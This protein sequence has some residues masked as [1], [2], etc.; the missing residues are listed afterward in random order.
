MRNFF[1]KRR[2]PQFGEAGS[3]ENVRPDLD[4]RVT[5][6]GPRLV[7]DLDDS[8][9][10]DPDPDHDRDSDLGGYQGG[11]HAG[12]EDD[13]PRAHRQA[14]VVQED[15]GIMMRSASDLLHGRKSDEL[16]PRKG[17][18]RSRKADDE[19]LELPRFPAGGWDAAVAHR[20][21]SAGIDA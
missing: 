2:N 15:R 5:P 19:D 17:T 16:Q 9:D 11:D 4:P 12:Y 6:F 3:G 18:D 20:R 21:Q 10:D 13:R 7:S 8:D 14:G 1:R